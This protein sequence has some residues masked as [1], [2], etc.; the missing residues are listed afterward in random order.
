MRQQNLTKYCKNK[1]INNKP[2]KMKKNMDAIK[3]IES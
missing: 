1:K 3:A 2:Y